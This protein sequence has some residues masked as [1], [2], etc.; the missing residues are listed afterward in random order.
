MSSVS[1]RQADIE[2]I[3]RAAE[4]TGALVHVDI[5]SLMMTITPGAGKPAPIDKHPVPGRN[6]PSDDQVRYGKENWDEE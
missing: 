3:I 5:R 4:R 6:I 1:F 2:R